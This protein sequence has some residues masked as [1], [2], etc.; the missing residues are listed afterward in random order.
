MSRET[1]SRINAQLKRLKREDKEQ[2]YIKVNLP[3]ASDQLRAKLDTT[4]GRDLTEIGGIK[5]LDI[6]QNAKGDVIGRN[7]EIVQKAEDRVRAYYEDNP[8]A[9]TAK[10]SLKGPMPDQPVQEQSDMAPEMKTA[11]AQKT[12]QDQ[13][14]QNAVQQPEPEQKVAG[15]KE[16][17]MPNGD[18][19]MVPV[20]E[21]DWS[22]ED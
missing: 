18:I 8:N 12:E 9:S 7:G 17:E 5:P 2:E 16:V 3:K 19:E 4:I 10:T 13:S 11:E 22:D 1:K 21:D 14:V 6:V 20:Y 15:Y